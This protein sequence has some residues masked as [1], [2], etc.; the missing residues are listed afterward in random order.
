MRMTR[1]GRFI[2]T[3]GPENSRRPLKKFTF[4]FGIPSSP[5]VLSVS[6]LRSFIVGGSALFFT[7]SFQVFGA[8]LTV[9]ILDIDREPGLY[10]RSSA[11]Q[12]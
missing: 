10:F 6:F 12:S 4:E 8:V 9:D 3:V 1:D 11:T 5:Q 2:R 7:L